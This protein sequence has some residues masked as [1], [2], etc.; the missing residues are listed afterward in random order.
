MDWTTLKLPDELAEFGKRDPSRYGKNTFTEMDLHKFLPLDSG[1]LV[2]TEQSQPDPEPPRK[3]RSKRLRG[4]DPGPS[5]F[6]RLLP[7]FWTKFSSPSTYLPLLPCDASAAASW[8]PSMPSIRTKFFEPIARTFC[9][10]PSLFK[11]VPLAL[12]RCM[13]PCAST[14]ASNVDSAYP[15]S[16][17]TGR[18]GWLASCISLPVSGSAMVVLYGRTTTT[19]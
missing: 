9:A 2:L 17:K 16:T 10:P 1:D 11:R 4:Q 14:H 8:L 13:R 15:T 19:P 12:Q 6:D 18:N 3:R 7:M 5:L